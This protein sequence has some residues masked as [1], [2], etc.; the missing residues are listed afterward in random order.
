MIAGLPLLLVLA[1]LVAAGAA[2]RQLHRY[3][4]GWKFAFGGAYSAARHDLDNARK[5]LRTLEHAA[6]WELSGAQNAA[7]NADSDHRRQ[8]RRAEEEL[9]RLREPG[10]GGFRTEIRDLS[11]YEHV[12]VASGTDDWSGDI[13]LPL[14]ETS[15]R[16]DHSEWESH[17]YLT[18]PDGRRYLLSYPH[19][20]LAEEYVRRFVLDVQNAIARDK[21]FQ[22][23]RPALIKETGAELRRLRGD[24]A[25][26]AEAARRLEEVT[27]RQGSDPRIPQARQ[28]LDAAQA[29]WQA[30]TGRR[31]R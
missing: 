3:P 2:G 22:R 7:R 31:P 4:G 6:R 24:A 9:A 17:V 25:G 11:L 1:A 10:R 28:E 21:A 5:A 13:Q 8:V 20:E 12:L 26:P 16:A 18:G 23:D 27:A 19:A 14:H 29:R 30:L 15:I